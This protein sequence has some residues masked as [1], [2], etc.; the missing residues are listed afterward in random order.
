MSHTTQRPRQVGS[1]PGQLFTGSSCP[2]CKEHRA[3][4]NVNFPGK[5]ASFISKGAENGA[6]GHWPI[7]GHMF[8]M[9]ASPATLSHF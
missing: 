1:V 2:Q 6:Q 4:E 9:Y 3:E 7:E 5:P 8:E